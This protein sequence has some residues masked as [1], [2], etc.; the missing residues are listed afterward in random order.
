MGVDLTKV[1]AKK[2]GGEEAEAPKRRTRKKKVVEPEPIDIFTQENVSVFSQGLILIASG[3]LH[4]QIRMDQDDLTL[5]NTSCAECANHYLPPEAARHQP[6][7]G[8][9]GVLITIGVK[10]LDAYRQQKRDKKTEVDAGRGEK[11]EREVVTGE[12]HPPKTP[13]S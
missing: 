4:F 1:K 5:L 12:G 3:L 10:N 2:L 13:T 9:V 6:L 8:L 7:I 11:R